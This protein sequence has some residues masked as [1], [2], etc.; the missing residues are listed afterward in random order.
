MINVVIFDSY[1]I[2]SDGIEAIIADVSDIKIVAKVTG[3]I[4][5]LLETLKET[6][7]HVL[8]IDVYSPDGEALEHIR[9]IRRQYP[10][11][12]ILVLS[13]SDLESFVLKTIK[14][15]AKG[16]LSKDTTRAELLEAIYTLRNGFDYYGKS[17]TNILLRGYLNQTTK[18]QGDEQPELS[19]REIEVLRLLGDGMTNQEIADK[20]F[21]SI[22]T[23]ESHKSN[24]MRKINL[25]TTVD[26]VKFAIRNNYI[27]V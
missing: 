2:V 15:G 22:R 23:V 27:D 19:A 10:K 18:N 8:L 24:I 5:A 21:V 13:M 4:R 25:R 14:A 3:G 11:I 12:S 16:Y 9:T 6:L 7:C 26:L 17:T 20:L 1:K